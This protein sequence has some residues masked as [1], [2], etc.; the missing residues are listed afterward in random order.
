MKHRNRKVRIK[1]NLR[2]CGQVLTQDLLLKCLNEN[3]NISKE[4]STFA[5]GEENMNNLKA[6][7]DAQM[8]LDTLCVSHIGKRK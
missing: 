3:R 5:L 8:K 6:I 1:R 7:N 4:T 2:I